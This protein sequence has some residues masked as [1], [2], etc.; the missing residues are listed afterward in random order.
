MPNNPKT[1]RW[2]LEL[3]KLARPT[4]A[5]ASTTATRAVGLANWE[6]GLADSE[7]AAEVVGLADWEV[8]LADSG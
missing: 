8:N 2:L 3:R 1:H 7:Q 4:W 6:I 5:L